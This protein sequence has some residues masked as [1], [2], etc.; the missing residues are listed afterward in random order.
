MVQTVSTSKNGRNGRGAAKGGAREVKV[1]GGGSKGAREDSPAGEATVL[2]SYTLSLR[3]E[4]PE[5][6]SRLWQTHRALNAGAQVFADWL[7]TLGGGITHRGVRPEEMRLVALAWLTV[8]APASAELPLV[9]DG[10]AAGRLEELLRAR[11]ADDGEVRAWREAAGAALEAEHRDDAVWVDRDAAFSAVC[12]ELGFEDAELARAD[13]LT[14]WRHLLGDEVFVLRGEPAEGETAPRETDSSGAGNLTYHLFSHLFGDAPEG[15]GKA[16]HKL[17]YRE[18]W[19][20]HLAARLLAATGIDPFSPGGGTRR[21]DERS[22][23]PWLRQMFAQSAERVAGHRTKMKRQEAERDALRSGE[24]SLEEMAARAETRSA[25]ELLDEYRRRRE[26]ETGAQRMYIISRR[27]LV[28]WG[29]VVEAWAACADAAA[30]VEALAGLQA[31]ARKGKWG[32]ATLFAALAEDKFVEV[33]RGPGGGLPRPELLVDYAAGWEARRDVRRL[34]VAAFRH[35]DPYEHPVFGR[36]GVSNPQIVFNPGDGS[37]PPSVSLVLWDGALARRTDFTAASVRLQEE[38][39]EREGEARRSRRT[40]MAALAARAAAE[41]EKAGV[42]G[43]V[44]DA[45]TLSLLKGVFEE[46]AAGKILTGRRE[47]A[48]AHERESHLK[49]TL[50]LTLDLR[51]HGP[52]P[53]FASRHLDV[54]TPDREGDE[55]S[56]VVTTRRGAT[57]AMRFRG[58]SY[59]FKR[60]DMAVGWGGELHGLPGLRVL[61]VDLRQRFGAACAVWESLTAEEFEAHRDAAARAGR[62]VDVRPL[63]AVIGGAGLLRRTGPDDSPTPWARLVRQTNIILPGEERDPRPLLEKEFRVFSELA[64]AL[65]GV[66]PDEGAGFVAAGR[67]LL[68]SFELALFEHVRVALK[69]ARAAAPSDGA[70]A[71]EGGAEE[72][73]PKVSPLDEWRERDRALG[74]ILGRMARLLSGSGRETR[75][76][77]RGGLSLARIEMLEGLYGRQKSFYSRPT[78][79]NPKGTAAPE[80]FALSLRTKIAA[81]KKN[82]VRSLAARIVGCALGENEDGERAFSHAHAVVIEDLRGY[83]TAGTQTRR[84]NRG[85]MAWAA[86]QVRDTLAMSCQLH[87]LHLREVPSA[88]TSRKSVKTAGP[89]LRCVELRAAELRDNPYWRREVERAAARVRGGNAR[90]AERLLD[91][92]GAR[93][94]SGS[95]D[96]ERA[97]LVPAEAGILLVSLGEDGRP[98]KTHVGQDAAANIALEALMDPNFPA[99]V[100]RVAAQWKQKGR[101]YVPAA[102][103]R[104]S[105]P[106]L[107]EWNVPAAEG[108]PPA[109][110]KVVNLWRDPSDE[111]LGVGRWLTTPA[112]W[113]ERESRICRAILDDVDG[114]GEGRGGAPGGGKAPSRAGAGGRA[115]RAG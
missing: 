42:G 115:V 43:E 60:E 22:A 80:D 45:D 96:D 7:L 106:A 8:E 32:D 103:S 25:V 54:L 67:R 31:S 90:P 50:S 36:F 12:R 27:A 111:P 17:H 14:V 44:T 53:A 34:R 37:A 62:K 35:I 10:A 79:E 95:L 28:G 84:E 15:F 74:K 65:G 64:A 100:W 68:R 4:R 9:E 101:V 29:E 40:R 71:V 83:R 18:R 61:G 113:Q 97:V 39:I 72:A 57:R 76:R 3:A 23:N 13:A 16:R 73:A 51:P 41:E 52:W 1:N 20:R 5:A 46:T 110:G 70:A 102:G 98:R 59:P 47:L 88:Y 78:P 30:R 69:L 26:A 11:R 91:A 107:A 92:Y 109:G 66:P 112:Y 49:W 19:A 24:S 82:R 55:L 21:G 58:P 114:G 94:A 81:L 38:L 56:P 63:W 87:G 104:R 48:E 105:V 89:A 6:M 77:E 33:W 86:S 108:D 93:L 85:L 99:A 2:R 75:S